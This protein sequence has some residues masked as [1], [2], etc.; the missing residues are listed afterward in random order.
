MV[1]SALI[2]RQ[3]VVRDLVFYAVS[4]VLL[5]LVFSD[6]KVLAWEMLVFLGI[7]ILYVRCAKNRS[8]WLGY[9]E[10]EWEDDLE[11]SEEHE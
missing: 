9:S 1:R 2:S 3:P 8:K 5:L 6:G 11:S 4:I 7:Y 10:P